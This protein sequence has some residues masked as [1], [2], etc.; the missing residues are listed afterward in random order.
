MR[1]KD[2][3]SNQSISVNALQSATNK[4]QL[5]KQTKSKS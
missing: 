5:I 4:K 3:K 1:S 2:I